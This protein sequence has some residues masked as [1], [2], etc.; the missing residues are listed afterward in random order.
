VARSM[1]SGEGV[2]RISGSVIANIQAT[3]AGPCRS[4][5]G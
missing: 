2:Q 3:Q 1:R 4:V 5:A